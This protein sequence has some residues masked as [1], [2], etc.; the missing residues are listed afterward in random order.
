M[1]IHGPV[2]FIGPIGA[3]HKRVIRAAGAMG[4]QHHYGRAHGPFVGQWRADRTDPAFDRTHGR[5]ALVKTYAH[6]G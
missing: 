1:C 4:A 3:G 2:L 5:C 6:Y